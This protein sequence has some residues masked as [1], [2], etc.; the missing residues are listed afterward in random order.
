[1][2]SI[3]TILEINC[4]TGETAERA[5]TT[6]ERADAD[7]RSA[8]AAQ[9]TAEEA[10]SEEVRQTAISKLRVLGLTEEEIASLIKA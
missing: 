2:N 6:D 1:M 4:E 8:E 3:Y 10:T 5:M 7:S 9:R